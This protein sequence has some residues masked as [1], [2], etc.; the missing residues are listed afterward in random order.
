MEY[1]STEHTPKN[2]MLIGVKHD[3]IG[4]PDATILTEIKKLKD[5][6]GVSEHYL[7]TLLLTENN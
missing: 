2:I 6:H 1:I 7:E 4:Q 5:I 3:E